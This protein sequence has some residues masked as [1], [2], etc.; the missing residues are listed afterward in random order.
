MMFVADTNLRGRMKWQIEMK[1]VSNSKNRM[2]WFSHTILSVMKARALASGISRTV[3]AK[4]KD[5]HLSFPNQIIFYL[6]D[7]TIFCKM[8]MF[9]SSTL[10][11]FLKVNKLLVFSWK[12]WWHPNHLIDKSRFVSIIMTH[13]YN[14]K[15]NEACFCLPIPKFQIVILWVCLREKWQFID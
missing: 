10:E 14:Q 7:L 11:K 5:S 6:V 15:E 3:K 4:T 1:K 9:R 12:L 13:T 2:F 8:G